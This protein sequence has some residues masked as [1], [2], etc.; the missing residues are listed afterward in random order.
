MIYKAIFV[1][2]LL[3]AGNLAVAHIRN[4]Y[5]MGSV[6]PP[7]RD[8][9]DAPL[10]LAEWQGTDLP[11]DPRIREILCARSGID[12]VYQDSTGTEVLVHAVWTDD[13]L[14]LHFPQQCYRQSGWDL[15]GSK[16][17]DVPTADGETFPARLLSFK[18]DGR[19]I[20][21]L[22][23]FQLGD[24]VFL[25][26]LEHRLLRRTVCWGQREWP[27]LMK[28]MLETPDK[29]LERGQDALVSLSTKLQEA[30]VGQSLR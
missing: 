2:A 15:T 12:R 4:G 21:V 11:P 25:D 18:R 30:V 3:L 26:R 14:R 6:V 17:V 10:Q 13:Y 5:E 9:S 24:N 8:L 7:E 19:R 22:Y 16:D 23:W 20:Q 1:C 29:G 27:P 28:F